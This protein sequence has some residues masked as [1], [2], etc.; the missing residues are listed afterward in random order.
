M[1]RESGRNDLRIRTN[2]MMDMAKNKMKEIKR[3]VHIV[4]WCDLYLLTL[5]RWTS[6]F[7]GLPERGRDLCQ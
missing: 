5:S 1:T 7:Y 4:R 6:S 2:E 3:G